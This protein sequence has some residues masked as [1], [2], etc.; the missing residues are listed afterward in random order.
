MTSS[1]ESR[2]ARLLEIVREQGFTSLADLAAR[3][4]VSE[5]TIRRD[6][7]AIEQTGSARRIH[8]GV[9]YTGPT[10]SVRRF[11]AS[12]RQHWDQKRQIAVR[13]AALIEET[14]TIL[15]DGGSTTYELARVL[16]GRTLQVVTNSL[17]VAELYASNPSTDLIL[18]GGYVHPRTG[19]CLGP[20]AIE[21]L[22]RLS[23]RRAVISVAGITEAGLYNSNLLLVETERAM[24]ESA[25]EVIVV[26]DSGKF[27][28][29]SL[30]RLGDLGHVDTIV[31]DAQL[32]PVWREL[33][34]ASGVRLLIADGDLGPARGKS[35]TAERSSSTRDGEHA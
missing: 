33:I 22:A 21:M 25:D 12:P 24:I 35:A 32:E 17:P 28:R 2:R 27:G 4:D 3:F 9:F 23:V 11:S 18:L 16:L 29:R 10:A 15:L 1:T 14:D 26:A 8:G 30:A 5:S 19:V 31:S 13:A 34:E 7:T 6:L 20:Y